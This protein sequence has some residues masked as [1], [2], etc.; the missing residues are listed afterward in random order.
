[1]SI[2]LLLHRR[3]AA[4]SGRCSPSAL[5]IETVIPVQNKSLEMTPLRSSLAK[6]A[7]SWPSSA[8]LLVLAQVL[9]SCHGACA[10]SLNANQ[11]RKYDA[12]NT[13]TKR[14]PKIDIVRGTLAVR[15]HLP[16]PSGAPNVHSHQAAG[17]KAV[18]AADTRRYLSGTR[19]PSEGTLAAST[20]EGHTCFI[21]ASAQLYC[22]GS[23]ER[24]RLGYGS[25]T[26][27]G[28]SS[29]P[30]SQGAVSL[31]SGRSAVFV[32]AG[33]GHT[34]AVL[35][36]AAAMCWGNAFS[37]RLGTGSTSAH[38][39]DNEALTGVPALS[40]PGGR[41]AATIGAGNSHTCVLM[42]DASVAC[43][44]SRSDGRLGNGLTS[45]STAA[46]VSASIVNLPSAQSTVQL[47]VGGTHTCVLTTL[48]NIVCWGNGPNGRLG[49]GSAADVSSPAANVALPGGQGASWVTATDSHTCVV[50]INGD[51]SCWGR[52][53]E[54]QL[55]Y[56]N[57]ADVGDSSTPATQGAVPL[58]S[59]VVAT[60]VSGGRSH[61]C[62]LAA[63]GKGVF[64]WGSN[65][66][67]QLG[68]GTAASAGDGQPGSTAMS[69][70]VPVRFSSVSAVVGISS[71]YRHVCE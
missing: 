43:W 25:E 16:F 61:T 20:G 71:G 68:G 39:G 48:G 5:R 7:M 33:A 51:V 65:T 27:V 12:F 24:G 41:S 4:A 23:G 49:Y 58:P 50:L 9:W 59:G 38:L 28:D 45:G 53:D 42:A 70:L 13:P 26:N 22:W 18:A 64:C 66:Q 17:R 40:L 44:G 67:G 54:G 3:I 34:C 47:A 36:N 69:A 8:C 46:A 19:T 2:F 52:G 35:D 1:M 31:P 21:T 55:G 32:S 30:Y 63:A 60:Q 57:L 6:S 37:G 62:I 11:S 14:T 56:G 15:S 10:S 29:T